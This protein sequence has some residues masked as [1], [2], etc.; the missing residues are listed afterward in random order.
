VENVQADLFEDELKGI[1]ELTAEAIRS[2][3]DSHV[4]GKHILEILERKNGLELAI[5]YV[6]I[7][8]KAK[9]VRAEALKKNS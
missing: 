6:A 3:F 7:V 4:V 9:I 8:G 2:S 1:H 5:G